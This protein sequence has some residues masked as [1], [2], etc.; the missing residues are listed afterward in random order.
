M[1]AAD[2]NVLHTGIPHIQRLGAALV[3]IADNRDHLVLDRL[4]VPVAVI[5]N[6]S[7][8]KSLL[9]FAHKFNSAL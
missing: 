4:N 5:I 1:D 6:L 7:H 2:D 9:H 3:A 8:R